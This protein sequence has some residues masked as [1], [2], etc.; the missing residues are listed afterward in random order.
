MTV[1]NHDDT[2]C[3]CPSKTSGGSS[4][5]RKW[6]REWRNQ[7]FTSSTGV[8]TSPRPSTSHPPITTDDPRTTVPPTASPT[9]RPPH[10]SRSYGA[11]LI[12]AGCSLLLAS[13][14]AGVLLWRAR[15]RLT[16]RNIRELLNTFSA[17]RRAGTPQVFH[18]L[19]HARAP[20]DVP[21]SQQYGGS[22]KRKRSYLECGAFS[23]G[24][25]L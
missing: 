11:Y 7:H 24:R 17:V 18:K 5:M 9:A 15:H 13:A 3:A 8:P 10:Q 23:P 14:A 21:Q 2:I 16:R 19:R 25:P 12:G 4:R 20:Q 6:F 22:G 1:A